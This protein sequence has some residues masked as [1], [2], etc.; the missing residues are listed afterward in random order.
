MWSGVLGLAKYQAHMHS[1]SHLDF[2]LWDM[3]RD[4]QQNAAQIKCAG[5]SDG[6]LLI[7]R[8]HR[9]IL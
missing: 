9:V 7:N 4:R 8:G 3:L 2:Y 6:Q 5:A 1:F